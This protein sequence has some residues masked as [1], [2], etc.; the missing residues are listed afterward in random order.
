[1]KGRKNEYSIN[2]MLENNATL[3][4]ENEGVK[5]YQL[6]EIPDNT[7]TIYPSAANTTSLSCRDWSYYS[8]KYDGTWHG[9]PYSEEHHTTWYAGKNFVGPATSTVS[10][11][12]GVII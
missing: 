11:Y 8:S 7:I 5:I 4:A 9:D 2:I 12:N 3:I 1:M 6:N 10:Y